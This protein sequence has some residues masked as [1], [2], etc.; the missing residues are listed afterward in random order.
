[1]FFTKKGLI[2]ISIMIVILSLLE[3]ETEARRKILRG[4]KTITRK[5]YRGIGFPGW[6]KVLIGSIGILLTNGIIFLIARKFVILNNPSPPPVY[7]ME[8]EV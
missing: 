8:H 2:I 4:R 6:F 5:Y 7:R 3:T 1:M